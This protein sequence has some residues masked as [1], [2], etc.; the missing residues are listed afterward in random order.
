[1]TNVKVPFLA[2]IGLMAASLVTVAPA[3][4]G[5][6]DKLDNRSEIIG[7]SGQIQK[8]DGG[9]WHRKKHWKKKKSYRGGDYGYG[10][11]YNDRY[12]KPKRRYKKRKVYRRG[13]QRGYDEG[14]HEGRRDSYHKRRRYSGRH[15][16]HYYRGGGGFQFGPG[17][18]KFRY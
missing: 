8:V 7:Q 5:M 3:S 18:F 16:D 2:V 4:A 9:S 6:R 1:M 15:D 13:F 12:Y 17:Y 14:Y 10:Y 11:G